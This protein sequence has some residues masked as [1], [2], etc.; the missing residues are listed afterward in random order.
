[1][2]HFQQMYQDVEENNNPKDKDGLVSR[3]ENMNL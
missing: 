3:R 1:M 2:P